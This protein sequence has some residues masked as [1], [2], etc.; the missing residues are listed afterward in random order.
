VSDDIRGRSIKEHGKA[1]RCPRLRATAPNGVYNVLVS[2]DDPIVEIRLLRY[3]LPQ[4]AQSNFDIGTSDK[5]APDMARRQRQT[6]GMCQHGDYRTGAS[7]HLWQPR[8]I[9]DGTAS[10]QQN[11]LA[12]I[13]TF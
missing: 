6:F 13:V 3:H 12:C 9:G 10:N 2:Q 7:K 8:A 1:V 11:A 5:T 4:H